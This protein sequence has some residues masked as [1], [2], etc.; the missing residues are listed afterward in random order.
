MLSFICTRIGEQ[1]L[2]FALCGPHRLRHRCQSRLVGGAEALSGC[3]AAFN[4]V[5]FVDQGRLQQ[6]VRRFAFGMPGRAGAKAALIAE[7]RYFPRAPTK[8]AP[9]ASQ[10]STRG[11]T[12]NL[13]QIN[14]AERIQP[15]PSAPRHIDRLLQ[16]LCRP[17]PTIH[18]V[19]R[20]RFHNLPRKFVAPYAV[21][22]L[23]RL[24]IV[25]GGG[26]FRCLPRRFHHAS[27][28]RWTSSR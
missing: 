10:P 20:H 9:C 27:V 8:N 13:G 16:H 26:G 12:N 25:A 18:D 19:R 22:F 23:A 1:D 4:K 5:A 15:S 14:R 2:L 7:F 17:R 11:S 6:H 3:T 28:G 24:R 21:Q